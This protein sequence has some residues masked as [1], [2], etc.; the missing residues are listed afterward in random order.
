MFQISILK[1]ERKHF[2][3]LNSEDRRESRNSHLHENSAKYPMLLE[4]S[5]ERIQHLRKNREVKFQIR[6]IQTWK[7]E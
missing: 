7:I 5:I 6:R 2:G 4:F 1:P 3:I